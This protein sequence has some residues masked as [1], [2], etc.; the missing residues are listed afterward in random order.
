V[1]EALDKGLTLRAGEV[2]VHLDPPAW[3]IMP[4]VKDE[5]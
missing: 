2:I 5:A 3:L 1:Q 4:E